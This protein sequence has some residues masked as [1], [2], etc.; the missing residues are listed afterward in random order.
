MQTHCDSPALPLTLHYGF[1]FTVATEIKRDG[2]REEV[3]NSVTHTLT[4]THTN[5]Y[6][7]MYMHRRLQK[8]I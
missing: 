1:T 2:E 7:H 4:D 3:K 6:T 5:T 8:S